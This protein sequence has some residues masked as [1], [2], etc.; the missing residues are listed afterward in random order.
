[1]VFILSV[2]ECEMGAQLFIVSQRG[3]V[4]SVCE[5]WVVL[6]KE[7]IFIKLLQVCN[8]EEVTKFL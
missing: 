1:M 8:V 2:L 7:S 6:N 4:V 3:W 5:K